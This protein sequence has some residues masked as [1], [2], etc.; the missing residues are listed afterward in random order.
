MTGI[1]NM[2]AKYSSITILTLSSHIR[3]DLSTG[4]SNRGFAT[5]EFPFLPLQ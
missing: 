2:H 3:L 5:V 1:L 4:F